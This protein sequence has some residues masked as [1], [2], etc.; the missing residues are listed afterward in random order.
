MYG[1]PTDTDV[2][3]FVGEELQVLYVGKWQVSLIFSTLADCSVTAEG[4]F[5]VAL[6]GEDVKR[7]DSSVEGAPHLGRLLMKTV[8]TAGVVGNALRLT[9]DDGS[10]VEIYDSQAAHESYQFTVGGATYVV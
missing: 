3:G 4:E 1:L 6:T 2:S 5:S 8:A 10:V 9:V 7:F